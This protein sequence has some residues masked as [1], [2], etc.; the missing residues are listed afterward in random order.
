MKSREKMS[1]FTRTKSKIVDLQRGLLPL[2]QF[3]DRLT[4]VTKLT[5]PKVTFVRF[6]KFGWPTFQLRFYI[7]LPFYLFYFI[8]FY[9]ITVI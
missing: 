6:L 8:L 4:E 5:K 9:L 2:Y 7:P 3:I 1:F